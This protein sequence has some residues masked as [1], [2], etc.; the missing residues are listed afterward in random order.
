MQKRQLIILVCLLA[1]FAVAFLIMLLKAYRDPANPIL[2]SEKGAQW[3]KYPHATQISALAPTETYSAFRKK[4]LIS[5]KPPPAILTVRAYKWSAVFWD[6]KKIFSPDPSVNNWKQKI[7][8][9]ITGYLT[10]GEH[11]LMVLVSNKDARPALLAYCEGLNLQTDQSWE[12]S[13]DGVNWVRAVS[14][15]HIPPPDIYWRFPRSDK[16][17]WAISYWA[18]PLFVFLFAL[19]FVLDK[20]REKFSLPFKDSAS[21]VRWVVMAL[22]LVLGINHAIKLPL[23]VGY[24]VS[25]HLEYIQIVARGRLPKPEE[26]WSTFQAP[27]Y[28]IISAPFY[29]IFSWLLSEEVSAKAL[30]FIPVICGLLRVEL[31]YRTGKA[32]LPENK[33]AQILATVIGAFM[34]MNIY[35]LAVL[36]NESLTSVFTALAVLL[37]IKV[38]LNAERNV[39]PLG[40]AMGLAILSKM[41][42]V[43]LLPIVCFAVFL[44]FGRNEKWF[45][46]A[47]I[48]FALICAIVFA[49]SGWHYLRNLMWLSQANLGYWNPEAHARYWQ[50][51]SYR[52]VAHFLR[53]GAC[54]AKPIYS[55]V[56]GVW[57]A[58]YSTMW[59]DGYLSAIIRYDYRPPWNYNA[60]ISLSPLS[61]PLAIAIFCSSVAVIFTPKRTMASGL[62]I[63]GLSIFVYLVGFL[64]NYL[65]VPIY[66]AGKASYMLGVL[67]C[68]AT[69][70]GWGLTR[71]TKNSLAKAIIYSY[72]ASWA[73]VSFLAFFIL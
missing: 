5:S 9:D 73:L 10:V 17:I 67:P 70:G 8:I 1:L 69:M 41:S 6:G 62:L 49:I 22:V 11:E 32:V 21:G 52:T 37:S 14:V 23:S 48:S 31:I 44:G 63:V 34:P 45:K 72:I 39:I 47:I 59:C 3:I 51:P 24:D 25:G 50:D 20:K 2:F 56:F 33:E 43:L 7:Q 27:L 19:F 68:F 58:L 12:V 36:N 30:R 54:L 15:N 26:G 29:L 53:F 42:G 46:R 35:H 4:I 60:L 40:V 18:L 64:Y 28:H 57:D 66:S 61:L 13:D 16:A 38:F 65:A 71:I 55:A